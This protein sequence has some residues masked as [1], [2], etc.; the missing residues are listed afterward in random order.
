M[1]NLHTSNQTILQFANSN[2][3]SND[4]MSEQ[5]ARTP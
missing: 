2:A 4:K 3:D 5:D 1:K